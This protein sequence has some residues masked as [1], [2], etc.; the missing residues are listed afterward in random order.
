MS[1]RFWRMSGSWPPNKQRSDVRG[2]NA[3]AR[4]IEQDAGHRRATGL[5]R[6]NTPGHAHEVSVLKNYCPPVG[7]YLSSRGDLRGESRLRDPP[8]AP[9][10]GMSSRGVGEKC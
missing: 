8:S 2:R 6:A 5:D 1:L 10:R 4:D 7:G 9:G 3:I